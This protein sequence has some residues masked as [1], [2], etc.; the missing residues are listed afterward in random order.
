MVLELVAKYFPIA[1][2]LAAGFMGYG[3]IKADIKNTQMMAAQQYEQI[4]KRL[5]RIDTKLYR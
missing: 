4:S 3:E 2:I 1:A 5:D